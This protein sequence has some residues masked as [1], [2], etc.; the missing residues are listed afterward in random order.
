MKMKENDKEFEEKEKEFEEKESQFEQL[1]STQKNKNS[2]MIKNISFFLFFVLLGIMIT[3]FLEK[4]FMPFKKSAILGPPS[5]GAVTFT[6]E[7]SNPKFEI[8]ESSS[9]TLFCTDI[10]SDEGFEIPENFYKTGSLRGGMDLEFHPSC[11]FVTNPSCS[12]KGCTGS[13]VVTQAGPDGKDAVLIETSNQENYQG[14]EGVPKYAI[15]D[16][17]AFLTR[18]Q[19]QQI[20]EKILKSPR[21]SYNNDLG[22]T[23][24]LDYD[25]RYSLTGPFKPFF[26]TE[27]GYVTAGGS[28]TVY[29]NRGYDYQTFLKRVDYLH[30]FFKGL[31]NPNNFRVRTSWPVN[32]QPVSMRMEADH[33]EGAKVHSA[34]GR[35]KDDTVAVMVHQPV[36]K[37]LT[38]ARR[39]VEKN[40]M[41]NNAKPAEV[42]RSKL[43]YARG[44][45]IDTYYQ[46]TAV[47]TDATFDM[48]PDNLFPPEAPRD[49]LKA[50]HRQALAIQKAAYIEDRTSKGMT[51]SEMAAELDAGCAAGFNFR[52]IKRLVLKIQDT[53]RECAQSNNEFALSPAKIIKW[54]RRTITQATETRKLFLCFEKHICQQ[55]HL[56]PHDFHALST[57][58][59]SHMAEQ[60]TGIQPLFDTLNNY[61]IFELDDQRVLFEDHSATVPLQRPLAVQAMEAQVDNSDLRTIDALIRRLHSQ[62]VESDGRVGYLRLPKNIDLKVRIPIGLREFINL[63]GI[64]A[65]PN[66]AVN[67]VPAVVNQLN[68]SDLYL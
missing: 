65:D 36:H 49:M 28:P 43:S 64:A 29:K 4:C 3:T 27:S 44:H 61:N 39:I 42:V 56:A 60:S 9:G 68:E 24:H 47:D 5:F 63:N 16:H 2:L 57:N 54:A 14:T 18:A 17:R 1:I 13:L 37:G 50:A 46:N 41:F 67:Q 22:Q 6:N 25:G 10:L 40:R 23:V 26:D 30:A 51:K 55:A 58:L 21:F 33:V 20:W 7:R 34:T 19:L 52:D 31:A 38:E 53:A 62:A 32:G 15:Q 12:L 45:D 66:A 8:L 35:D 48:I 11:T 59:S